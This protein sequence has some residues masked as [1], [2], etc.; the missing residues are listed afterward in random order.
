MQGHLKH[1]S[2]NVISP[3][4]YKKSNHGMTCIQQNLYNLVA[5]YLI[6]C[7][8]EKVFHFNQAVASS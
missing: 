4:I 6:L 3:S 8:D 2:L 7:I 1:H 5:Q